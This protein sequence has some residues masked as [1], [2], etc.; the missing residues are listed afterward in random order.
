MRGI[1]HF[2]ERTFRRTGHS[3]SGNG[4]KLQKNNEAYPLSSYGQSNGGG[5]IQKDITTVVQSEPAIA[6]GDF[7]P[8]SYKF[9][10][11]SPATALNRSESMKSLV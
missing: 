1:S 2:T 3:S 10:V 7:Q 5:N 6:P 11:T 9:S 8:N 4:S